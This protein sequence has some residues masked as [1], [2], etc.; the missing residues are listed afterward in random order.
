M[1]K[2]LITRLEIKSKSQVYACQNAYHNRSAPFLRNKV[3][4]HEMTSQKKP[5]PY[6][7]KVNNDVGFYQI[8]GPC[9]VGVVSCKEQSIVIHYYT[10]RIYYFSPLFVEL[11]DLWHKL[12]W[13]V[14]NDNCNSI[15][16]ITNM[17]HVPI[18]VAI[19]NDFYNTGK[20]PRGL[21]SSFFVLVPKVTGS[22]CLA[23]VRCIGLI[24][25]QLEVISNIAC[26]ILA[27]P[28]M[29]GIKKIPRSLHFSGRFF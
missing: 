10:I 15:T 23:D 3:T 28:I 20:L 26:S 22:S 4:K 25:D 16:I 17:Q 13:P 9:S 6:F 27:P 21:N 18:I 2:I 1:E 24:N 19:F 12:K 7:I 8:N 11:Q 5:P 29:Q 14:A